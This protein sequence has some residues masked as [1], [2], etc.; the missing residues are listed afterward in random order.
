MWGSCFEEARDLIEIENEI[1]YISDI[2]RNDISSDKRS[3]LESEMYHLQNKYD[4]I[5]KY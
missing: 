1:N 4:R 2:L 3:E 5:S